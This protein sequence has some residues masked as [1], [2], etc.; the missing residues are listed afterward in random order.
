MAKLSGGILGSV[1]GK[2][3]GVVAASWKDKNYVRS[4]VATNASN[5]TA[6]AAQR[7]LFSNA[8]YLAKL[9]LGQVINVY[10]D[11]FEKSQSGFN[12]WIK[13]N[14]D[15]CDYPAFTTGMHM[16]E[17]KLFLDTFAEPT[18]NAKVV[19]LKWATGLGT[20]GLATDKVLGVCVELAPDVHSVLQIAF[21]SMA[22]RSTGA[23]GITAT[24]AANMTTDSTVMCY[25]F[26]AQY[27]LVSGTPDT[28]KMPLMVSYSQAQSIS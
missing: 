7:S 15:E 24:F 16:T 28:T 19:T 22:A 4:Y 10:W 20:N 26:A 12:A 14:I 21:A 11:P 9:V 13:A 3:S 18:R 8:V 25:L 23:T 6:Q 17:G 27:P 2:V 5:S 1:S